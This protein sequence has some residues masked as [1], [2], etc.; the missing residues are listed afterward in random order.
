MSAFGMPYSINIHLGSGPDKDDPLSH[1]HRFKVGWELLPKEIQKVLSLE[2]DEKVADIS[3]IIHCYK[4][5][6][7]KICY[8]AHHQSCFLSS[9]KHLGEFRHFVL[10]SE[11]IDIIEESWRDLSLPPTM[12]LSNR[13]EPN[14]IGSKSF[15]HSDYL[16]DDQFNIPAVSYLLNQG[17]DIECEAKA[18]FPAVVD[19]FNKIKISL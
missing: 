12:H 3:T 1:I 7:T 15:P 13:R 17:F 11:Q 19:F 16:Y 9:Q 5:Y 18:K 8:D 6:G 2:N 14:S 10:S 4:T